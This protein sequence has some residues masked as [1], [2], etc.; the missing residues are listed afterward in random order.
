MDKISIIITVRNEEYFI[1]QCIQSIKDFKSDNLFTT[2]ILMIDGISTDNTRQIIEKL[3]L[4]NVKIIDNP[5]IT[6]ALGFNLGV[7]HANGNWIAWLGALSVYPSDYLLGLF[8][9]ANRSKSEYTGGII[10]TVP[11]NENYNASVV[12]ALTTHKFGVG[13]SGFRTGA[14]EGYADTASY[15][16]FNKNIFS[17]IGFLDERLIRAQDYEFNARIR[18]FGGKVWLNPNLVVKYT[19]Q[20]NLSLFLKKQFFKEA[21]YN[22]YMWYLAPYTFAYRH[23]ITGVF[24]LGIIAGG[25]LSYYF[26]PIR[27]IYTGVLGFYF[28]LACVSAV[29]QALRYKKPLHFITLPLCFFSY[30]FSH[31]LGVL[32][33]IVKL[34]LGISPVQKIKEPW[35]GYGSFRVAPDKMSK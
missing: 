4:D 30:H 3:H 10:E 7:K 25:V 8:S 35:D 21:P 23:A 24:S 32:T 26:F 12:Q 33:G 19:N 17:E 22:T 34:L 15:G 29:Q 28:L 13:N 27:I 2:E 5:K 6:Q 16:L 14:K 9:S 18:R 1:K 20:L 31:G 11:N